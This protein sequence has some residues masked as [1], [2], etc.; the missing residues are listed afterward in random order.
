M[1]VII[2]D[3]GIVTI[4]APIKFSNFCGMGSMCP[5]HFGSHEWFWNIGGPDALRSFLGG[6]MTAVGVDSLRKINNLKIYVYSK[7]GRINSSS[8]IIGVSLPKHKDTYFSIE[9]WR[10]E[11][12]R[13]EKERKG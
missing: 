5:M 2:E 4:K 3:H 13:C 9:D 10:K 6:I 8:D 12:Q 11:I 1:D 7:D